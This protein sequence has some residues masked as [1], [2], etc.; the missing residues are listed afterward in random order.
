M[1][2]P[3]AGPAFFFLRGSFCAARTH[4]IAAAARALALDYFSLQGQPLDKF[5]TR[6]Y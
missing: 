2:G 3:A 5:S 4:E 1:P 6:V